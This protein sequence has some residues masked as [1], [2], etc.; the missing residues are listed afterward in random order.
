MLAVA[1]MRDDL[2]N[3]DYGW[4]HPE[5]EPGAPAFGGI[6]ESNVNCLTSCKPEEP[7]I[8]TW[9]YNAVDCVVRKVDRV[10]S[11]ERP[12]GKAS[13]SPIDRTVVNS[14]FI[15]KKKHD[16]KENVPMAEK[17]QALLLFSKPPVP[18]M[19]KT[20]LTTERGGFLPP[21]RL[22]SSSSAACTT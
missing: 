16:E 14:C 19:V 17:K 5:W 21:S 6:W 10:L 7:M 1:P 11:W 4:W 13:A 15:T 20:R 22:P 3:V 9:C 8:G 18:G 12:T 2:V